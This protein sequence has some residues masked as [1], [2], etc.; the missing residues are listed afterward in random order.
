MNQNI[1]T[2]RNSRCGKVMFSQ[3]CFKNSVNG[4]GGGVAWQGP[5]VVRGA[6]GG[7]G[8]M[9]GTGGCVAVET[10][11]AADGTHPTGMHSCFNSKI[12]LQI[13]FIVLFCSGEITEEGKG[14]SLR[15][16]RR[17]TESAYSCFYS[18]FVFKI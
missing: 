15:S 11:I 8:G 6:C 14:I 18:Y 10:A 3:A 17:V 7:A 4:R 5:C 1:V 13:T 16:E 9:R 12:V 2:V